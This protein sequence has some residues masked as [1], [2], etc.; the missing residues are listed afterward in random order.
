MTLGDLE[1]ILKEILDKSPGSRTKKVHGWDTGDI[2]VDDCYT[3]QEYNAKVLK[4]KR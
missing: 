1:L 4:K 2:I 3:I